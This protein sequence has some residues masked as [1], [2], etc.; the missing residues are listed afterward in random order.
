MEDFKIAK[1]GEYETIKYR[2]TNAGE[3]QIRVIQHIEGEEDPVDE[4]LLDTQIFG[5]IF[6][7]HIGF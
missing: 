6:K 2:N 1:E 7:Y 5:K 4:V 3:I